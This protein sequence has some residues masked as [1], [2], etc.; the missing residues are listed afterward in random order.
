M[1]NENKM[2]QLRELV[3]KC[4]LLKICVLIVCGILLVLLSCFGGTDSSKEKK[5]P[6]TEKNKNEQ[7]D[8][9]MV[10]KNTME[11]QVEQLLSQ[12]EGVG[13][14]D[15][16]LTL[17][18]SKE[19]VTLKDHRVETGKSEEESVLVEDENHNTAP[20]VVQEREPEI[21]GILVVCTGGDD[22][23]IQRE[24][25]DAISALFS[26]ESHKIKVMKSKEA[27]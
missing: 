11:S 21:E 23:G 20:Y 4:G 19:K 10:Y 6:E 22:S 1:N 26:V 7:T 12:V 16:M 9:L 15:V 27:K 18:A 2:E 14:A 17:K 13:K 3:Q 25:I 8:E 5:A 24:I